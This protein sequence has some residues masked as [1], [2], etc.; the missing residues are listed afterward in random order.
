MKKKPVIIWGASGHALVVSNI[1]N[2]SVD[3]ELIG[4]L[5]DINS[6]RKDEIFNEKPI[7]GGR[8]VISYLKKK[9]I[10]HATLGF[11][12]CSG[13]IEIAKFLKENDF[14]IVTLTHPGAIIADSV[15]IGEGTVVSAG[16]VIDP[17]CHVGRYTIINNGATICH[18][19][20]IG[21]GAHICPGVN[22]AGN[23]NI[24]RCS[25]VGIG[26]CIISGVVIGDGSY[27]GAGSVVTH[28]IPSNVIAFGN[29]AKVIRKVTSPF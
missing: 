16:V 2:L 23:I 17:G 9:R 19:S 3:Y 11:G 1:L 21:D 4:F 18:G 12:H 29:P 10:R 14:Q 20:T 26:T 22:M 24:G 5:D 28:D 7:L 6:N 25:W 8:E 15:I 13:R 27:I